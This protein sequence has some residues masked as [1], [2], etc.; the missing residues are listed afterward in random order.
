MFNVVAA[1][2]GAL[3]GSIA[4]VLLS[5]LKLRRE[6]GFDRRLQWCESMM[7][8]LNAAGAAVTSA[9]TG[10]DPVGREKCWTETI[11]LYEELIPLCG[12]KELYA[13]EDAIELINTFM[14][15][16]SALIERHLAGHPA[17]GATVQGEECLS[18]IRSTA[19]KL[20]MIG[21]SHLGLKP[22]PVS[23]TDSTGRFLG[24]FR[25]RSLGSHHTALS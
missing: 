4:G 3:I 12:Q 5:N 2:V 15:E 22:L 16:L 20:A 13:P 25:G 14:R 8:A 1:I 7:A 21:R 23:L 9:S 6:R 19:G 11:R 24:S 17:G 10:S 18:A